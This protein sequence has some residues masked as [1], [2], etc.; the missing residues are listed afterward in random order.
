MSPP[1]RLYSCFH[2]A[3]DQKDVRLDRRVLDFNKFICEYPQS[4]QSAALPRRKRAALLTLGMQKC[5]DQGWLRVHCLTLPSP[6]HQRYLTGWR[7]R[8]DGTQ[9]WTPVDVMLSRGGFVTCDVSHPVVGQDTEGQ[10]GITT[11]QKSSC[12]AILCLLSIQSAENT[13]KKVYVEA[14]LRMLG[15]EQTEGLGFI[16][17]QICLFGCVLF[18]S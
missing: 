17:V 8:S 13:L 3:F 10:D 11:G 4:S 12:P 9:L 7:R 2:V 16:Y 5:L 18:D 14:W 15:S 6:E 1:C